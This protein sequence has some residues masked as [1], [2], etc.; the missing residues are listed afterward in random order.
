[1]ADLNS[2]FTLPNASAHG[3]RLEV[4]LGK[5]PVVDPGL[6]LFLFIL[7]FFCILHFTLVHDAND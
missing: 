6:F 2:S 5:R 3:R 1:M 7:V 4:R